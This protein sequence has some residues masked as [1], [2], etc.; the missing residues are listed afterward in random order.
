SNLKETGRLKNLVVAGCLT[1]RYKNELVEGLP[2]GDL[3]VGS[4]EFPRIAEILKSRSQG[5]KEKKFFNLPTYLQEEDTPRVNSQPFWRAYLKISEGCKKRCSFCAI[6]KIRGNLQSR[7][8]EAVLNEAKL[9]VAG[10][11]KEI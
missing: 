9:L 6:P 3:F 7:S 2:E 10:G 4:G 1:Q 8:V 5:S 11:V